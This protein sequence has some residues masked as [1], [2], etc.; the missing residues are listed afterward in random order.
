MIKYAIYNT[1][2]EKII[3]AWQRDCL[4]W[5]S[6][7]DISKENPIFAIK[8]KEIDFKAMQKEVDFKNTILV[9]VDNNGTLHYHLSYTV[10]EYIKD[11]EKGNEL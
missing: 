7:S 2:S 10:E 9:P 1:K 3:L 8:E 5:C 11:Y 6:I 4:A